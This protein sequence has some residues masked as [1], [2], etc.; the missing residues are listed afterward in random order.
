[1][2]PQWRSDARVTMQNP[3]LHCGYYNTNLVNN[4]SVAQLSKGAFKRS[5]AVCTSEIGMHL[6]I[7][8][9]INHTEPKK[10]TVIYHRSA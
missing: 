3:L 5:C 1:M 2:E 7:V 8:L 9:Y 6:G 4:D 10:C